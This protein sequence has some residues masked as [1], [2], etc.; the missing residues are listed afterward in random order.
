MARTHVWLLS[1]GG[2]D[3]EAAVQPWLERVY[4]D[5]MMLPLP[6][7]WLQWIVAW[8]YSRIHAKRLVP[9]CRQLGGAVPQLTRVEEQAR[10][11]EGM[12]GSRYRCHAVFR[13]WGPSA[14]AAAASVGRGDQVVLLPMYPQFHAGASRAATDEARRALKG[15]RVQVAQVDGWATDPGYVGAVANTVREAILEVS[16]D[17][18][19]AVVFVARGLPRRQAKSDP[20]VPQVR[21]T[22]D[23]VRAAVGFRGQWHLSFFPHLGPG[24]PMGPPPGAVLQAVAD[25]GIRAVVAVPLGLVCEDIGARLGPGSAL[26]RQAEA[27]GI[28]CFHAAVAPI[29]RPDFSRVLVGIVRRAERGAGWSLPEDQVRDDVAV[30]LASQGAVQLS[31]A[32][33]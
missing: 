20:Y 13:H 30:E 19:Y 3:G 7:A 25:A 31:D 27:L 18:D 23:A 21:A 33:P 8:I 2:P 24:A 5:P 11:L 17:Q 26:A 9:A 12:L 4:R 10:R 28:S 1:L 16:R 15:K 32:A 6:V 29:A 22:A 14:A